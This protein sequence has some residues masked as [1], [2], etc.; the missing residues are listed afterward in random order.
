MEVIIDAKVKKNLYKGRTFCDAPEI[1]T[2]VYLTAWK[3][4][5]PGTITKAEII[6]QKGYDLIGQ[7]G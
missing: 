1:D 7:V 2:I 5:S 3:S 4:L 6:S